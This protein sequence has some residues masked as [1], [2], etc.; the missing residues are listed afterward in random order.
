MSNSNIDK[1][2]KKDTLKG[3]D[4]KFSDGNSDAIKSKQMDIDVGLLGKVFGNSSNAPTNIAGITIL[5]LL[6]STPF[7]TDLKW[8]QSFPIIT[9]ALGYLF[10]KNT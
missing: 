3:V 7:V 9:L 4:T 8:D 5:V 2:G 6:F 1:I 10:G